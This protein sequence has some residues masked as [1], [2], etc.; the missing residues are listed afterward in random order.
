MQAIRSIVRSTDDG[1]ISNASSITSE[2]SNRSFSSEG[3]GTNSPHWTGKPISGRWST[4][5][6]LAPPW[7]ANRAARLPAGPAPTTT[8]SNDSTGSRPGDHEMTRR[9]LHRGKD[10]TRIY[11]EEDDRDH[12]E[13]DGGRPRVPDP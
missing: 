5:S 1:G 4:S 7:A 3:A 10:R 11:P 6:V 2:Q 9:D 8:T 13:S 12:R